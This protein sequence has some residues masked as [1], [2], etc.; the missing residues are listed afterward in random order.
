M[1]ALLERLRADRSNLINQGAP[2]TA[3]RE[4]EERL[5]VEFPE[6]YV[7]FLKE[8][9]GGEFAFARMHCI[10]ENGAGWFDFIEQARAFFQQAPLLGLRSLLPFARSYGSNVYCFDMSRMKDGECPVLEYDSDCGD[11]QELRCLAGSLKEWIET[12]L[13][14]MAQEDNSVEV[15]LSSDRELSSIPGFNLE[16]RHEDD[17]PVRLYL[18]GRKANHYILAGEDWERNGSGARLAE[19]AKVTDKI[20]LESSEPIELFFFRGGEMSTL[21]GYRKSVGTLPLSTGKVEVIAGTHIE[22]APGAQA[23]EIPPKPL[24]NHVPPAKSFTDELNCS[25]CQKTQSEVKKLIS[26]PG[27]MICD[28][29]VELCSDILSS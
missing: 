14:E 16:P 27:V 11:E 8:F 25:F 23:R 7:E 5:G 29:C 24:L 2:E 10:T 9:D 15:F 20:V 12:T 19:L 18:K 6:S 3:I 22:I 1:R 4:L 17:F 26:G 28:E 21:E 13:A